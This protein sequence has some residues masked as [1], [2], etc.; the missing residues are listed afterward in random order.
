MREGLETRM[1]I[2]STEI[3]QVRGQMN[4][5]A[6][7]LS[8][9]E[10]IAEDLENRLEQVKKRENVIEDLLEWMGKDYKYRDMS[11]AERRQFELIGAHIQMLM[12]N[13]DL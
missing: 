12:R 6:Q 13:R 10:V 1:N 11:E 7:Y 2:L 4:G 3:R 9:L 8:H 5:L